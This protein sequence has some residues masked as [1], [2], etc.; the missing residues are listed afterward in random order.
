MYI[1]SSDF[2][3]MVDRAYKKIPLYFR[4]RM[5]N[6]VIRIEELPPKHL[7]TK[8]TTLLGLF[9]GIPSTKVSVSSQGVMPSKITLYEK[10]ILESAIS[11]SDLEK[12]ILEVLMHEIAHYFGYNDEEMLHMDAKLRKKL[13]RVEV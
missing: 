11:L 13:G 5:E 9:E 8:T 4:E 12:L 3:E 2:D 10:T 7:T 6:V 1:S